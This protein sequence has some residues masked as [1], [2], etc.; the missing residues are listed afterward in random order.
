MDI[1]VED[2]LD[3]GYSPPDRF[4]ASANY[5]VTAEDQEHGEGIEQYTREE[6][7]D[8][9]ARAYAD[10]DELPSDD[11]DQWRPEEADSS[12]EFPEDDEVGDR[13]SGRLYTDDDFGVEASFDQEEIAEDAGI[14]GG[15]ASAEE[16]AVHVV[17]DDQPPA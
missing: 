16:A 15:A 8:P 10:E 9:A 3:E 4:P 2:A 7:P 1:G 12:P 11:P 17:D 5:G 13:R 6:V 14:D